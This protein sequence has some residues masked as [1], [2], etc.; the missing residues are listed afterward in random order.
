MGI[1][2]FFQDITVFVLSGFLAV[3]Q[4]I[5]GAIL[6]ETGSEPIQAGTDAT[7][8]HDAP[9]TD[10]SLDPLPSSYEYGGEIPDI[11]I[12]NAAFQE[13]AVA[14]N[15]TAPA[16]HRAS[17]PPASAGSLASALVNLF[18]QIRTDEHVRTT[19]GT[20]YFISPKGVVLTNAHV[21]QFLLL[22]N[23]TGVREASC[24]VRSGDP[25]VAQYRAKLLYLPPT[26]VSA[27][28]SLITTPAPQASGERDYA[29]LYVSDAFEG[30]ALPDSFPHIPPYT[31]LIPRHATGDPV[32]A[33]GYPVEA[34]FDKRS[35]FTLRPRVATT[36]I[37]N[38]FTFGSNYA[39]VISIAES[40]VG[41]RGSS[42]GPVVHTDG[43]AIGLIVT[44]GDETDGETTSL[45]AL[46]L[47]YID[48]TIT[49][50]TGFTLR[51]NMQ[52]NLS[53][54]AA[55]YN[56]ALT[57]VLSKILAREIT[58]FEESEGATTTDGR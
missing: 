23:A 16:A 53:R 35:N 46:T 47:S 36:T 17:A 49:E 29:L 37:T 57:P 9:E 33:A 11:L 1:G 34:P 45:R 48:R 55:V 22:E 2:A 31:G 41:S 51:E 6:A 38:L 40:S 52:G 13:A 18:C 8:T 25:A 26:W 10:T 32:L 28:A 50:E 3:S 56:D 43:R 42:G 19:T 4:A 54:R 21:A 58:A 39:D 24:V 7:P 27:H 12:E 20:G 14:Q 44:K 30:A 5:S 15:N